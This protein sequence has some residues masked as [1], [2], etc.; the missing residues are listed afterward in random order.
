MTL[1]SALGRAQPIGEALALMAVEGSG[2]LAPLPQVGY[3][4][5]ED[6]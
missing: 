2:S 6:G 1:S 3:V 4:T 5:K